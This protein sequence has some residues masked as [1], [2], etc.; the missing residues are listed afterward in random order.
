MPLLR[1]IKTMMIRTTISHFL[2]LTTLMRLHQVGGNES[3]YDLLRGGD[4]V[5]KRLIYTLVM[6]SQ[7]ICG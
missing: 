7:L 1:R 6:P 2:R 3:R 5:R 4:G